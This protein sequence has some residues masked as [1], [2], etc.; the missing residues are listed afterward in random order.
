[1]ALKFQQPTVTV[2]CTDEATML[3]MVLKQHIVERRIS[4]NKTGGTSTLPSLT[5]I[6]VPLSKVLYPARDKSVV[7]PASFN[8]PYLKKQ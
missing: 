2:V 7:M 6:K 4:S 1:M 8:F 5:T 3:S